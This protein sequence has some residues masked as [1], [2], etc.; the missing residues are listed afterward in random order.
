MVAQQLLFERV[1]EDGG[2]YVMTMMKSSSRFVSLHNVI[3]SQD[4][5]TVPA[6]R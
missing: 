1:L 4:K 2:Q 3:C 5:G 6:S